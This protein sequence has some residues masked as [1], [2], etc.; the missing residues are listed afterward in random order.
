MKY[1]DSAIAHRHSKV[2][3]YVEV[4]QAAVREMH[5]QVGGPVLDAHRAHAAACWS[6]TSC[7]PAA[8]A[9]RNMFWRSSAEKCLQG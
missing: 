9:A 1:G 3:N 7:C 6:G 8:W 4:N 2:R 5:R